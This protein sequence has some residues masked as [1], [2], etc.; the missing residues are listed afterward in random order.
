MRIIIDARMYQESGVG[1]Y[2]RN[3]IDQLQILDKFNEYY[4]LHLLNEYDKLVYHTKFNKVLTNFNW[5]GINEQI[6]LPKILNQLNPDLVHFP[7]FNM[8]VFKKAIKNAQKILVPSNYVKDLLVK[9]WE[10]DGEKIIVT[11]EAV[12]DKVFSI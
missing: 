7:H 5:Y 4:I 6:K 3:L 12:D 9:Q 8:P 11:Y 10:V 1:R 2:I